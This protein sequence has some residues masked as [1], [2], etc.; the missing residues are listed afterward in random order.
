MAS[1]VDRAPGPDGLPVVGNA[2]QFAEDPLAF[3]TE[4]AR[5]YGPVAR[6]DVARQPFYQVSDPDLVAHVLVRNN[7][8]YCK[9]ELFQQTLGPVLGKGLLTSEGEFWR[10]ERH[11]VEPAFHPGALSEYGPVM[12]DYARGLT[13]GWRDGETRNVH[14]DMMRLTVRI[15][16]KAL[17]DIDIEEAEGE[18]ADALE[19]VMDRSARSM[20]RPFDVPTWLPLSENR[21]Y[22]RAL[23]TLDD[24]AGRIVAE[25]RAEQAENRRAAGRGTEGERDRSESD[26]VS[27][28]LAAVDDPE[29]DLTERRVRDE[30]VTLLLAGHETTALALTYTFHLLGRH[31]DVEARLHDEVDALSGPPTVEDLED[32]AYTDRV[33]TEAMRLYPPVWEVI[34]EPIADDVIGGFR[35]PAGVTVGMQQW[36]LHR[37]PRFYDDP[38][39][40]R[41][42]RWTPAFRSSLPAFAYFPF[43]GGPRR[44]IGDRFA[45]QEA[46]LVLATVA[47][48]WRLDPVEADLSFRPSITLRPSGPVE[49]I[50]RR[51]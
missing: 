45:R 17:F 33:I 31:P 27:L 6:Y 38:L 28:L 34:R 25:R 3:L 30:I 42:E 16:A 26:A 36:V 48:E 5:E 13:G 29:T 21:R 24:V 41:P 14:A 2:L 32:L 50:P 49:M 19:E 9:G 8:N 39:S 12:T 7:E 20:R 10:S 11:R 44:C 22:R 40:F 51:R 46:R 18:V 1:E 23:E 43:G 15:A 47:R 4:T 35:V 37:D